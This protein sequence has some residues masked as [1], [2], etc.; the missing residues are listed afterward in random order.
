MTRLTK[1]P[2]VFSAEL[3]RIVASES[4]RRVLKE[5]SKVLGSILR[6]LLAQD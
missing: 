5:S 1:L 4:A 6:I 2:R 3:A